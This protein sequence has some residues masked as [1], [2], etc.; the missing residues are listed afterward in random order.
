M[1]VGGVGVGSMGDLGMHVD[2]NAGVGRNSRDPLWFLFLC[3]VLFLWLLLWWWME[4]RIVY[5][6]DGGGGGC[7]VC[8]VGGGSQAFVRRAGLVS[9][10]MVACRLTKLSSPRGV[11]NFPTLFPRSAQFVLSPYRIVRS[12]AMSLVRAVL[13]WCVVCQGEER[14][15]SGV[16][17]ECG[18]SFARVARSFFWRVGG[19]CRSGSRLV[20]EALG[21]CSFCVWIGWCG[22][23]DVVMMV[24]V[25]A[26]SWL[27]CV[28]GEV[29]RSDNYDGKRDW[30]I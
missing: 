27:V 20:S 22:L 1:G 8:G 7:D 14:C 26:L 19:L 9:H 18:C 3:L 4:L 23:G 30:K 16:E 29:G 11:V 24:C 25:F 6:D 17:S 15:L 28:E 2:D 12:S 13:C 5:G 10:L 21:S